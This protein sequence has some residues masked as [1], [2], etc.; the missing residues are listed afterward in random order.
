MARQETGR[1]CVRSHSFFFLRQVIVPVAGLMPS[2]IVHIAGPG[3]SEVLVPAVVMHEDVIING[4]LL[5]V[6]CCRDPPAPP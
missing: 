3:F 5:T 1:L 6:E 4:W 2:L